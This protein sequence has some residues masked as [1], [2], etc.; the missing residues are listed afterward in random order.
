MDI[1]EADNNSTPLTTD[2]KDGIK[3][4]WVTLRTELNELETGNILEVQQWLLMSTPKNILDTVFLCKLHKKMFGKVWAWA[5]N[6]RTSERNI[7]V[8]PYQIPMKLMY[9][10][11]DVR[12]WIE[13]K[14]YS[15]I[16]ISI[17]FHHKLVQIHPFSNCNGR[18]SRT[19][20]DLLMKQLG[21]NPLYWGDCNLTEISD[22]RKKYIDSLRKADAGDY[23]DLI[24]FVSK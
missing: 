15:E 1:F 12:Y 2:E 23:S 11:D 3:L 18:I 17:R 9:L 10:F 24:S 16:E 20:A 14:T 6:Y 13:N 21:Q 19:M 4:K 7:G 5:G 22:I 8:E